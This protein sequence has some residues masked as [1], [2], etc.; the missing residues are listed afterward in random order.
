MIFPFQQLEDSVAMRV[1]QQGSLKTTRKEFDPEL[2]ELQLTLRVPNPGWKP[3]AGL[4]EW[5]EGTRVFSE[6]SPLQ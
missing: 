6:V 2:G 3:Q 4:E 5:D 1:V